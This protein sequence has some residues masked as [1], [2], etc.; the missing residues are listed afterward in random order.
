MPAA[1]A[2]AVET[3]APS[4]VVLGPEALG[5]SAAP[6]DL[7]LLPD[8][9]ILVASP[10]ELAFGDGVRWEAFRSVEELLPIHAV[11]VDRDGQ[12][13][14]GME[15]GIARI[16]LSEGARWHLTP[17]TK[18][19][20]DAASQNATLS[21]VAIFPDHWYWY[22]G[23]GS[24]ISWRPGQTASVV[25]NAAA[26]ERI[27]RL[28]NDVFASDESS[29]GLSLLRAGGPAEKVLA[30]ETVVSESVTS[31]IPFGPGQLLVGTGGAGLKIFDGKTFRP[32]GPP[33]LLRGRQRITDLC[34]TGEG[35]FAAAIDT[36]GIVFFDHEG[37]TVQVLERSLDHRLARVRRLQYSGEGVLWA[38]LND[39]VAR[40]EFPSPVSHFESLLTSGLAYAQPLRHA[41]ELW[42]LADGR[43]MRG[44]YDAS[45][46]LERFEE[47]TPPGRFMFTLMEV[48][49]QLFASN[50]RGIF[51]YKADRWRMILGGIANARLGVANSTA[52]GIFYVA[53][54]EY[55]TIQ[56]S[57]PDF[58]VR[59]IPMPELGDSYNSVVDSAGI[60]WIEL[61]MSRVGRLDPHGGKPTLQILGA[62][63]GLMTS[64]IEAYVLD[65]VARFHAANKLFRFDDAQWKFVEDRELLARYPQLALA[66]GRPVTD[67]F[68]RLWYTD[69]GVPQAIDRGAAGANLSVKITPVGFGPTIYTAQD[70]GVVWMF[71]RR[72]LARMDLRLPPR[73]DSPLRGLITS[74]QFSASGRR[75]FAPAASLGSLNYADNSLVIHFAAPA[76][77]FAAPIT[78]EVL[79]E[80]AGT[81]W[82]STGAV[83]S[84]AFNRLKEGAY[85]FRVRP[86][87][88]GATR[89][90]EARL[91]FTVRPP[92]F[93]T[94]LAWSIYSVA[95]VGSFIF[96]VWLSS[97][98]QRRKNE[99]LE[100]LVAERTEELNATN[101]QLGR[102]I[103]E[104]TEK[105]AALSVSEERYRLL[106]AGLEERV[107]QRTAELAE[108]SGLL[109]A[110]L[111]NTPDLIYFKNRESRFVRFSR[112]F[113]Q[114]FAIADPKSIRGKTDFD[115]FSAEHAQ[116][117]YDDEQKII[118]TGEAI[119][120]KLEK[121]TYADGH[122]TWAL[123]TKM[124]WRDGTGAIVGS[125]GIS[126]DVTA[127][128]EAEASLA[129]TH[130][131]LVDA[132]RQAGMA[133]VATGV[134][135]NVG[136]VLNSV[137]VSATLVIDRVRRT[138]AVN[139]GKVATLL[140]E[141]KSDLAEFL[142]EDPRGRTIPAY[143]A[144]LADML[145]AE[146]KQ[147]VA[148][149][150]HLCKNIA[151]I[152]D[153]V[154]MQQSFARSSGVTEMVAVAD[155]VEDALRMN[156]DSLA[157][158]GVETVRDFQFSPVMPIDRHK[159]LQILV[160]LIGNAKQ[161][162]KET[163]CPEKRVTVRITGD[164]R[165][166]TIAVTDN[167]VGVPAENLARIFSHGFTTKKNGHGF[168]LHSGAL[169]AR[170]LGGSLR[171]HSDGI[172]RGATFTLEIP[173]RKPEEAR[174]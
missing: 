130:K 106:N 144:S 94:P 134:L 24:I 43:A 161:A 126:K 121:E 132:S 52:D 69:H 141:H 79:L 50:E 104:T 22:G 34:A 129:E 18:L 116:V 127:W 67:S 44:V 55:G 164:E 101:A 102:Q 133:E 16:D 30:A 15:G 114:R 174:G 6:V 105:S 62:S 11:A 23:S 35:F 27:F 20:R 8:G 63:D 95:T 12:I 150:E 77:P 57:G 29:G 66:G 4:F 21:A 25:G 146:H 93:R 145:A 153:I 84:A 33:G 83:G 7:Q 100:R 92:W 170:E 110:M 9:R 111:E 5:L 80:G 112:A 128:K 58:T 41:G 42:I 103:Q 158:H 37:R 96:A 168:G 3:G 49:G 123:T 1:P 160:N 120:G 26:S 165:Q 70:D 91:Q 85:V 53:R 61:G 147:D 124:P 2:G 54:G 107:E 143:L 167:G 151:H 81:Q 118:R 149:L 156:A 152:K 10:R 140:A 48:D 46:R 108:A 139:L 136:N 51:I 40:V 56:Q 76:N 45:K 171:V 78:F 60:G 166:V 99:R 148:E 74:V 59:Q 32:F 39:G 138:K 19:P 36:V 173:F 159:V 88:G 98:L 14:T 169:A 87:A 119:V 172:G 13:Y 68:G 82:V 162:C 17:L 117:A 89:G 90:A 125:F 115:F 163:G 137:N 64:W 75:L 109:D 31:A 135:H 73:P 97:F 65:G 157:G 28:G 47:N 71:A 72:R 122:V 86:V 38:L 142:T 154:S 131:R 113:A 155:L